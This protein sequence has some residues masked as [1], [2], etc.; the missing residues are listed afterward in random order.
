[1]AKKQLIQGNF[2]AGEISHTLYGQVDIV[3]YK[4]G[5]KRL[6]NAYVL[7]QGPVERRPGSKYIAEV[8]TSS[9][10]T[11]LLR[12]QFNKS[13]AYI[14]EFGDQYIRFFTDQA[15]ITSGGPAYEIASPYLEADLF[16]IVY[17]QYGTTIYLVHEDYAPRQ[18]VWTSDA[19]WELSTIDFYP[20]ATSEEGYKPAA[21]VT[22]AATTGSGIN[23]TAGSG[24]FLAGDVG[25]QIVNLVG[26]GRA[27]ITAYTSATVVV[28][29]IVEDFPNTSAI[30]S[31]DWKLDLSPVVDLTPTGTKQG[32]I[33]TLD[34]DVIDT[35]T[36]VNAFR[37]ADIGKVV[38]I[39]DGVCEITAVPSGDKATCEVQKS[40]T[41]KTE[42]SAFA[43][44]EP[45]WSATFGYPRSV[46]LYQQRLVFGG[47][48]KDPQTIWMSEPGIFD[49]MGVGS[50]DDDAISVDITSPEVSQIQWMAAVRG[51]L[52]IGTTGAE[53]TV[54]SGGSG[55]ITPS[56]LD[57]QPRTY[58]G[59]ETQ[60][61][62]AIGN[63]V[64]YVQGSKKKLLSFR[65][66]FNQ[67]NFTGED[68]TFLAGHLTEGLIKEVAY[69][70]SPNRLLYAVLED[71]TMM[72]GTFM[73][74]QQ[75]LGWSLATTDGSYESVQVIST[76]TRDEVWVVVKRT[77][78]GSTKRYIELFDSID[79]NNLDGFSDSFLVL[80][81]PISVSGITKANPGVVTATA[82]G[83]SNGD[84]VKF[85]NIE[86]MSE[87]EG[88]TFIVANQTANTFELTDVNG[89]NVDTTSYETFTSGSCYK[90]VTTISG[91][92]HL[93]AKTVSVR[94]DGATHP[95]R[96]VASGS[97]TLQ[98]YAYEVVV[99]LPY[100]TTIQLLAPNFDLGLGSQQGQP[101][102]W[103]N[104]ILR[105]YKSAIPE[106]E[107]SIVASRSPQDRMDAALG[108]F[109]GDQAYDPLTWE[110]GGELEITTSYPLPLM[111]N[112]VFGTVDSGNK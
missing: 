41:A 40:L 22:P 109:T 102:R 94:V 68:L 97:I 1:M 105:L 54:D 18:L 87:I 74:E 69:A 14:L 62:V 93:E 70:K 100:T 36:T 51:A 10:A 86:G 79:Y 8:K 71:G 98:D 11:R 43:I 44:E 55:P 106:V 91:L 28:C 33:I 45:A 24:V 25:R 30:A 48:T 60:M 81:N 83:L 50:N 75:V 59:S 101:I 110:V 15:Q 78:N 85:P 89:D 32:S 5:L 95:D 103:S 13:N 27:S 12:F 52:V 92:S 4:N 96:T 107:G 38:T 16:N 76:S 72:I 73:R 21:T 37:S 84:R 42:T 29:T 112:A 6:R 80:S 64:L 3:K 31:G 82:H 23:F 66:D 111:L 26:A 34:A 49:S 77:I 57:Q 108:L 46:S 53:V 7:P 20:E 67:D 90:L 35:T 2:T 19:D 61:P 99:G 17:V 56:S 63:E 47:T 58:D 39:Q 9:K 88:I 104:P 65:Y